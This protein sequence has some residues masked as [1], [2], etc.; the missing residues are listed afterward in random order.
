MKNTINSPNILEKHLPELEYENETGLFCQMEIQEE[1]ED[2]HKVIITDKEFLWGGYTNK[3]PLRDANLLDHNNKNLRENYKCANQ[4]IKWL[5]DMTT[6]KGKSDGIK[7]KI[8]KKTKKTAE[9]KENSCITQN[10]KLCSSLKSHLERQ[11]QIPTQNE[12]RKD[13]HNRNENIIKEYSNEN[14]GFQDKYKNEERRNELTA[15]KAKFKNNLDNKFSHS[16]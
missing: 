4:H 13:N 11:S 6:P 7:D 15:H 3:Q 8:I 14:E 12:D 1:A 2:K 5:E 16:Q 10:R 9:E